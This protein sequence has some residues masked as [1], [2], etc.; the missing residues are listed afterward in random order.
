MKIARC[1][2]QLSDNIFEILMMDLLFCAKSSLKDEN[3]FSIPLF[4][5]RVPGEPDTS[6]VEYQRITGDF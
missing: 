3:S 1:E 4:G 5:V 2:N 6:G